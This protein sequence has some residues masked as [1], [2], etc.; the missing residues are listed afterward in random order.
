MMAPADIDLRERVATVEADLKHLSKQVDAMSKTVTEI[1]DLL[2]QAK[3]AAWAS[4][5][6]VAAIGFVG[7]AAGGKVVAALW[8]VLPK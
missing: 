2:T 8:S 1:R 6:W 4:R 5:M 7:G 3:G